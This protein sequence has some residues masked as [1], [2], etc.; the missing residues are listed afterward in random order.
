M[1]MSE[2]LDAMRAK[3]NPKRNIHD[4]WDCW[5]WNC[6]TFLCLML[7]KKEFFEV[8]TDLFLLIAR[9]VVDN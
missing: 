6:G 7:K 5:Q 1:I 4:S 3:N 8:E 2:L 9:G